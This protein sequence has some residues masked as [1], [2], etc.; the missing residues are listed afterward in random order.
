MNLS[1]DQLFDMIIK[2]LIKY[3][4]KTHLLIEF[5]RQLS[6]GTPV[7]ST[8]KI[9]CHDITEILLKMALNSINLN[10]PIFFG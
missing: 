3:G 8:N 1:K 2:K 9:D 10:Q 4:T 6:P 5:R 7:F